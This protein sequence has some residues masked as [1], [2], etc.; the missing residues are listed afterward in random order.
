MSDGDKRHGGTG[1]DSSGSVAQGG[2]RP[3]RA[4]PEW[5]EAGS[6]MKNPRKMENGMPT[7]FGQNSELGCRFDF[8]F[9]FMDLSLKSKVSN[10]FKPNLT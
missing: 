2:R 9:Y 1:R 10:T 7:R 3:G 5:A 6:A 4:G 8:E